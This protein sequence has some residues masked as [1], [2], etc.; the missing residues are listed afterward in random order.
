MIRF[1]VIGIT[2]GHIYGQVQCLLDVGATFVGWHSYSHEEPVRAAFAHAFP[3]VPRLDDEAALLEDASIHMI[4]TS[5]VPADR[6]PLGI[7]AMRYGK[8]FMTDKPGFT[9]LE[10][11]HEVRRV[12]A[13]TGR[14]YSICYSERFEN[15]ATTHA[16][17]LVRSGAIG[18]VVQTIGLG[19][20]RSNL[21]TR[22]PYFFQRQRYGG[23][24]CDIG[25]H[26]FDQFLTFTGSTS[27]EIV[28]SQVGNLAHPQHPE[29]EDFG[30]ALLRGNNG[31]G[32]LRV[33]WFTPNGLPVWG[34]GR[35][36]VLG[37]EGYIEL[38]KY[39]DIE[40]RP[41]ANHLFLVNGK[42]MQYINCDHVPLPYGAALVRDVLDRSE[43]AMSQVHCFL[44]SELALQAQA[45][46]AILT[47]ANGGNA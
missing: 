23:I 41:G 27:A 33:D 9:T 21:S 17:D 42:G 39:V 43:T 25:S 30:D 7:R 5:T 35:L 46:A 24:L 44:V 29:L 32:Y 14:I 18:T 6:A 13:E 2:H 22:L 36:T 38:R 10:Q 4:V 40:G 37:T 20:H 3:D 16:V 47:A 12:Q 19:P 34:D 11:L 8:D 31:S 1:A 26:Q 45:R 15:R 28:A